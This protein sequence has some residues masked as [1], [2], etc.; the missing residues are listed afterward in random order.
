MRAIG[1][2]IGLHLK[3]HK[4]YYLITA[5]LLVMGLSCGFAT[6]VQLPMEASLRWG[7]TLGGTLASSSGGALWRALWR[8]IRFFAL[9]ALCG[10]GIAGIPAAAILVAVRG[11]IV[12]FVTGFLS[13]HYGTGGFLLYLVAVVPQNLLILPAVLAA[14]SSAIRAPI[15]KQWGRGYWMIWGIAFA[16]AMLGAVLEAALSGLLPKI[17]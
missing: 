4:G 8:E 14:A 17:V 5:F 15:K 9:I 6:A 2:E 16:G 1:Y 11:F 7:P 13:A 3:D 10:I 12:G